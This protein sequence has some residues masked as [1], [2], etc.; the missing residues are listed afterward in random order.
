MSYERDGAGSEG[1]RVIG[2]R[3]MEGCCEA[4]SGEGA[5]EEPVLGTAERGICGVEDWTEPG[6]REEGLP[7]SLE[8]GTKMEARE[9]G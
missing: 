4:V 5:G 3:A 8:A 9:G 6:G 1:L 2:G 7:G